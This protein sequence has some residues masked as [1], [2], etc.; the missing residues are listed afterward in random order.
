[1]HRDNPE[2]QIFVTD[3]FKTGIAKVFDKSGLIGKSMDATQEIFIG[4]GISISS[5]PA[6]QRQAPI[7]ISQIRSMNDL[8][9]NSRGF[10][11][12]KQSAGFQDAKRFRQDTF[13]V[14]N[15]HGK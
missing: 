4:A 12:E 3:F 5:K 1:M 11:T 13:T 14:A 10:K 15:L 7:H 6:D 8:D 9:W 2:R